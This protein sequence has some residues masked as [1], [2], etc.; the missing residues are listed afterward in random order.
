MRH[1]YL[2]FIII[3]FTLLLILT[4]ASK[5][6]LY[7]IDDAI[8]PFCDGKSIGGHTIDKKIEFLD[9]QIKSRKW[10]ENLLRTYISF[11]KEKEN[12]KHK[13]W[14][15]N[16]RIKEKS[17]K[18]YKAKILVKFQDDNFSCIFKAKVRLTGDLW[19]HIDWN[20]GQ[21]ISSMSIELI[22]GHINSIT[23]FKLFLPKSR[24]G[25][26]EIFTA[27]FLKEL[28]FL[29]P[30][31]FFSKAIINGV[32]SRFIFQ[33]DLKKEFLENL[34]FKEGPILEGDER[35]SV[36]K[37]G[38]NKRPLINLTRISNKNYILKDDN[39]AYNALKAVTNLNLIYLQNHQVDS[40]KYGG[41]LFINSEKF[42]KKQTNR[43][44]FDTYESFIYALDAGHHLSYDDRRFYFDAINQVFLPIYYDG[45]SNIIYNKQFTSNK[46]L[47]T[48]VSIS[49]KRGASKALDKISKINNLKFNEKLNNFG[50]SLSDNEY[51]ELMKKINLRLEIIKKSK[52]DKIKYRSPKKHFSHLSKLDM[53]NKRI[54]FTNFFKKEFYICEANLNNC[55]TI[56]KDRLE[57]RELLSDALSQNFNK[58]DKIDDNLDYI[59]VFDNLN[60]ENGIFMKKRNWRQKQIEN[61]TLEY[62]EDIHVNINI[63]GKKINF[64]QKN[65]NGRVI[66]KG[67]KLK[68][69]N[70]IFTGS[71]IEKNTSP[72][73]N[74]MSLTGCLTFFNNKLEN[75]KIE[76]NGS[77]CEDAVN[78][79]KTQG[80]I[81]SINIT[82]SISDGLD[83]DFSNIII[84]NLS[85]TDS[86]NDCVDFSFGTYEIYNA[87]INQC[88]DK[89]ISVGEKSIV[90][91]DDINIEYSSIGIAAKDSSNVEINNSTITNSN[92]CFAAYRKKKEFSG[93]NI[94]INKI[95]CENENF[96]TK[97]SQIKFKS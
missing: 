58:F 80:V 83:I 7:N 8:K 61:F 12:S 23:E 14:F 44:I 89:A 49:A 70:I 25:A 33:E 51:D 92:Y 6:N 86:K 87:K 39:N 79:I 60:Y 20:N 1:N 75:L 53:I 38:S 50:L 13:N 97:G 2:T 64:T 40:Y 82:N 3:F 21:P 69:W 84:K 63:E 42:F 34:N 37:P 9:I 94:L 55:K 15:E 27:A 67:G 4:N 36:M 5:A 48:D 28:G 71:I 46:S 91:L 77:M 41:N 31:T 93:S 74:Y 43:E 59:F 24:Y 88:G 47:S 18:K 16:F 78:F 57:Y 72:S 45:K 68:D 65:N 17:K 30:R 81:S 95:E 54:V 22:D 35:F 90:K 26:N 10:T 85:V 62:N 11:T 76:A 96:I 56:K 52:P 73:D 29:S 19:W 32:E 66:L